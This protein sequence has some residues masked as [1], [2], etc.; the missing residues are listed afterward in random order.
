MNLQKKNENIE[1]SCQ[2]IDLSQADFP[3]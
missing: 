2:N 1:I 3:L